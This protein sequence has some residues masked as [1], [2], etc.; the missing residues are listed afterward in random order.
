MCL[1]NLLGNG[2]GSLLLPHSVLG[3]GSLLRVEGCVSFSKALYST[4]TLSDEHSC[5][6][7]VNLFK[8]QSL[9]AICPGPAELETQGWLQH[10]I[11]L[12]TMDTVKIA[13]LK[14]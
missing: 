13:T 11:F 6:L 2:R 12:S 10:S 8:M 4:V 14:T 9:G 5:P 7:G 1:V 3:V